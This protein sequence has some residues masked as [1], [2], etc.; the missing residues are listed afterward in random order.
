M[1]KKKTVNS[2]SGGKSSAVLAKEFP[3]DHEVFSLV[4]IDDVN[5]KPKDPSVVNYVN[6]KLEKFH[7]QYGEFIATAED[8]KTLVAMMDLEQLIGKP[9]TWIRGD[10]FD[11]VIDKGTKTRLPSWAIRYCT[12]QMKLLPMFIWWFQ[13]IGEKCEMRIGFRFDE[14]KRME[15]FW[16]NSDPNYFK[17]PIMCNLYGQKRQK[18]VEIK[19][20]DCSFPLIE[21][22]YT[23]QMVSDFWDKTLLPG[24]LFS[25]SKKI[26][27]PVVSNCVGCFHKEPETL[28]A[29]A[30]LNPEKMNWFSMQESKGKGKWLDSLLPYEEIIKNAPKMSAERLFEIT[31]LKQSC[32]SGGCSSD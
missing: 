28:A 21:K 30:I 16:N 29:M 6:Q 7:Y 10:S 9:I 5:S 24:D 20:R 14:F 32:D 23:R 4:C 2:I 11:R 26:E 25:G 1:A 3:A 31:H 27:F 8:D 22:G 19:W 17:I 18:L 12:E 13:N 15:R